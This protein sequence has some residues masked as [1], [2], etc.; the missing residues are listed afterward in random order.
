MN[1]GKEQPV[2]YSLVVLFNENRFYITSI[3]PG[4]RI[5]AREKGPVTG[6]DLP[7][8]NI[9]IAVSEKPGI[10]FGHGNKKLGKLPYIAFRIPGTA[11]AFQ[12]GRNI[13]ENCTGRDKFCGI[14]R[15]TNAGGHNTFFVD[16]AEFYSVKLGKKLPKG[17]T[18]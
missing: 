6:K 11:G 4:M 13:I 12:N 2:Y 9:G 8:T 1:A 7:D 17:F 14:A 18:V 10:A 16:W 5:R 15:N 3:K